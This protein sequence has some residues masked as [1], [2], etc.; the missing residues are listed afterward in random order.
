MT[1]T[2][3]AAHPPRRWQGEWIWTSRSGLLAPGP[4]EPIGAHDPRQFDQRILLRREFSLEE[5]PAAAAL[6]ATADARYAAYVNGERIGAGPGRHDSDSLTYDEWDIAS[7]LRP[8][9]NVIAVMARFYGDANP[10]WAPSRA[11]HTMGG[12]AFAAELEIDGSVV[13]A[14]DASWLATDCDAWTIA[15]PQGLLASQP[16]ELFDAR[17]FDAAWTMLDADVESWRPARVIRE[18]SVIGPRGR[19][20]PGGEPYGALLPSRRPQTTGARVELPGSALARSA[21]SHAADST[22]MLVDLLAADIT[23]GAVT[24]IDAGRIVSG[25]LQLTFSGTAGDIVRGGLLEAVGP[26]AFESA[27][28]L[29]IVLKDGESVLEP[30]DTVGGRYLVLTASSES[31]ELPRLLRAHVQEAHRPRQ[32]A[33]FACSDEELQRIVDLSLRTVD[34]SAADAYIDCP[35]REQRA[36]TG[37]SVVHQSVDL[38]ATAD[39]SLA[40]WNP[41]LLGR[42]RPDGILPMAA[43]GD[44]ASPRIPTIPDWSLHW[45]TSVHNLYRYTGDSTLVAP[46]LP[47]VESVLRWF[48]PYLHDGVLTDV[49]GWVLI[50]WSPVQ[51]EGSSAALTALW[52]RALRQFSDIARW[53]GDEGRAAWSDR[54]WSEVEAGFEVYWDA[55]RQ[56]YRDNILPDGTRGRSVSE[57]VAATALLAGLVPASRHAAIRALLADRESIFT[58]S[59]LADHGADSLGPSSGAPV[60]RRDAPDWDTESQ[61]VGAQPFFRAIVHDAVAA[62]GDALQPLYRDWTRLLASGPTALRECWEG[63][64]YCHGWSAT[65]ARDVIV[66]TLGVTPAEPG[67]RTVRIAPR[68]EGLDW[69]EARVPTPQGDIVLRVEPAL[70][71]VD[72]PVRAHVEWNGH[73]AALP[74]GSH[75]IPRDL[76]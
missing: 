75:R 38:V 28:P 76:R 63:G 22:T 68:L 5:S 52:A 65:V 34:L 60:W 33:H 47:S 61:V 54:V 3:P 26:A 24:I 20:T 49:P 18:Q 11:S 50:D 37:D 42:P 15:R 4:A 31:G 66:H 2:W 55:E 74:A 12:G 57:H 72:T 39:W 1:A 62:L 40:A 43:A 36:W 67:Y 23:A 71:V 69:A 73:V 25:R 46:L 27:A 14:T 30:F 16:A 6:F 35:T 7:L 64:S 70:L 21:S 59:P 56:A 9:R 8:G 51:V 13:V 48:L 29:Q 10:W 44:F 41:V 53:L 19:T 32:G 45:V 17:R 58:R